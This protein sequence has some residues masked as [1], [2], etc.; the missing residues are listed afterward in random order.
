MAKQGTLILPARLAA[1]II[2]H[3]RAGYPE[4]V[5]GLVGG[6]AGRATT[7]HPGRNISPTPTI[8]YELDHE[9]LP[10]VVDLEDAGLE[11][12]AIY[13]S[14]PHGPAEPSLVD[15]ANATFPDCVYLIISLAVPDRPE[16][17]GF[18]IGDKGFRQIEVKIEWVYSKSVSQPSGARFA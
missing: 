14:H 6:A 3:A 11:L 8:A 18:R 2:D 17:T 13:H 4:E 12:L 7:L 16:L 10:R 5:C 15:T 9:T 1:T